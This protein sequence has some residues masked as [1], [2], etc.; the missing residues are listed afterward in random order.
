MFGMGT[1]VAPALWTVGK[2]TTESFCSMNAVSTP[3]KLWTREQRSS[4]NP[5]A[6][7]RPRAEKEHGRGQ[8][9]RP[10]STGKLHT[11][12]RF[13]TRPINLV[14]FKES[15]VSPKG[16]EISCFRVGFPLRCFQR[17]SFPNIA[18]WQCNWHHNQ[19]TRGLSTPV[20]SY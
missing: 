7:C 5:G 14:V 19:H 17:L 3:E 12:L 18:T 6:F 10:I 9:A 16:E 2:T 8:A 11:L 4:P 20:L 1:G 15:T 13:H